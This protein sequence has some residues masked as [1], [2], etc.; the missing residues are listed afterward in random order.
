[1]VTSWE[2]E[3]LGILDLVEPYK[4]LTRQFLRYVDIDRNGLTV[5]SRLAL[6]GGPYGISAPTDEYEVVL[7]IATGFGIAAFLAYLK[8]LIHGY[9]SNS[10][11]LAG[12]VHR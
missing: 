2:H 12:T 4:G 3:K 8:Q 9:S 1:M 6:F 5:D 10:R 11:D 7:V